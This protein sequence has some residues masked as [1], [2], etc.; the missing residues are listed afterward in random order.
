LSRGIENAIFV[1]GMGQCNFTM[2]Y[3]RGSIDKSG[4]DIYAPRSCFIGE[5]AFIGLLS[6]NSPVSV[7]SSCQSESKKQDFGKGLIRSYKFLCGRG[8][9]TGLQKRYLSGTGLGFHRML[10]AV[11]RAFAC[12]AARGRSLTGWRVQVY[13]APPGSLPLCCSMRRRT[14]LVTPQ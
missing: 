13:F 2:L 8:T 1:T 6:D 10:Q 11:C 14:S 9:G 3:Y 5:C 4:Q 12:A 7:G